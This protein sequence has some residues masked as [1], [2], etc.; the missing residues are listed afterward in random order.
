MLVPAPSRTSSS[1]IAVGWTNVV[2]SV[3][4]SGSLTPCRASDSR[5]VPTSWSLAVSGLVP[6]PLTRPECKRRLGNTGRPNSAIVSGRLV[7][8]PGCGAVEASTALNSAIRAPSASISDRLGTAAALGAV[9]H[10]GDPP[11]PDYLPM[12]PGIVA[13]VLA[14]AVPSP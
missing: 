11:Q 5:W 4:T 14:D 8:L 10:A 6:E 2:G 7:Q 3:V 9:S 13:T 12:S 1:T